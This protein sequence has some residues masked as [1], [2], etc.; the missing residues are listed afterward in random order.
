MDVKDNQKSQIREAR[1]E[2]RR[3][4]TGFQNL[5]NAGELLRI[6]HLGVSA[7][8]SCP[9]CQPINSTNSGEKETDDIRQ[10][11]YPFM[12]PRGPRND[13]TRRNG[14]RVRRS[15]REEIPR[16]LPGKEVRREGHRQLVFVPNRR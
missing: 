1:S 14:Y 15:G 5:E 2:Q 16:R 7:F 13:C 10:I 12:G 3:L 11:R 8:C 4:Q 9:T 6:N